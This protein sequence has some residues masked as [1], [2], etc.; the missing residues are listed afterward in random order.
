MIINYY[1]IDYEKR[2]NDPS[3]YGLCKVID[4]PTIEPL[5]LIARDELIKTRPRNCTLIC[6]E[7]PNISETIIWYK[8]MKYD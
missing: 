5:P 6:V 3:R 7:L 2:T 1:C 4:L 8:G